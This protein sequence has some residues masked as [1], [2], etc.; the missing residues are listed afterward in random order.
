MMRSP[1][2]KT[3]G[4]TGSRIETDLRIK[5]SRKATIVTMP[6]QETTRTGMENIASTA[7][8]RTTPKK[9]AGKESEKTSHVK[10]NNDVPTSQ[11]C[12]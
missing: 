10:T 12:T 4:T 3:K 8:S 9:N 5:V 2:F 1:L 7:R 11:K 6:D